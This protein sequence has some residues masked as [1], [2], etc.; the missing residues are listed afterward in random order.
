MCSLGYV[1]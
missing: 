1:V